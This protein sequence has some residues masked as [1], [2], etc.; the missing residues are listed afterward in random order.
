[1][2]IWG[3]YPF[4]KGGLFQQYR[5]DARL[6]YDQNKLNWLDCHQS[7]IR[8]DLCNDFADVFKPQSAQNI[9][10]SSWEDVTLTSSYPGGQQ[11]Q[12]SKTIILEDL[13]SSSPSQQAHVGLKLQMSWSLVPGNQPRQVQEFFIWRLLFLQ[14]LKIMLIWEFWGQVWNNWVS[15][16]DDLHVLVFLH[17]TDRLFRKCC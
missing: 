8:P 12:D 7:I 1:M 9:D 6:S 11:Y 17:P 2:C 4:R 3:L 10:M 16:A 13:H 14:I 15:K 5:G